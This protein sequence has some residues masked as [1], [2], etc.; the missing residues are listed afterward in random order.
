MKLRS[1]VDALVR[2]NIR[3]L[4]PYHCARETVQTGLLL[5]ANENPFPRWYDR[6]QLNR[7]P[8]PYQRNLRQVLATRLGVTSD[9]VLA[10]SGSDEVLDWLFKIFD[11]SAGVA[12]AEPTYG[13]YRVLADIYDVPVFESRLD[14]R[15]Q[16]SADR[17]LEEI[18]AQIR[19]LI[20][21][22]PNNPTGNLLD[23]EEILKVVEEWDGVVVVDEAY[24]EFSGRPSLAGEIA[25]HDNLMVL[26]TFSKAFGRAGMRLGYVVAAP[27]LI[28]YLLKVKAP[29]NLNAW[30]LTEGVKAVDAAA[31]T[32][33]EVR[34]IT[35]ERQ[36]VRTRLE[37][38]RGVFEV[39]PSDANFILFRCRDAGG[40]CEELLRRQIVVRDRSRV[41]GLD[42]CI[43]LTIGNPEE[44]DTVLR[45]LADVLERK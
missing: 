12:L 20:V 26:R 34:L 16:F 28:A 36:R 31:E 32:S 1:P 27:A 41:P 24:I 8:D 23:S 10:G 29:Y 15:F 42:D 35:C 5:D 38:L 18:P 9:M 22:S 44:N 11:L 45:E 39:F 6:V 30:V 4:E 7:Y 37:G 2:A 13:M 19:M 40:V 33:R 25:R 17:F 14:E 21:C 43:R 3:A